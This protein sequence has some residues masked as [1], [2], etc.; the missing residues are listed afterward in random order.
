MAMSWIKGQVNSRSRT[1]LDAKLAQEQLAQE[2]DMIAKDKESARLAGLESPG[3]PS[4]IPGCLAGCG[5]VTQGGL[6]HK[7]GCMGWR[8]NTY[9]IR[10]GRRIIV[11][12]GGNRAMTSRCSES[13]DHRHGGADDGCHGGR[14][15]DQDRKA[16]PQ[17]PKLCEGGPGPIV[18]HEF[19]AK[20][21][22]GNM[23]L[24]PNG[25][26]PKLSTEDKLCYFKERE[27]LLLSAADGWENITL[28]VDSGASDTV[29]PPSV[30]KGAEI[31]NTPK[32]GIEY[33]CAN[34]KPL[35]NLGERRCDAML[36]QGGDVIGMAFQV[37]D[38]GRS[39]LSVSRVCAQG[40]DVVF[41][42]K[43]G[44]YIHLDGDPR[45]AIPLRN[46]GGVFE[47]DV[48]VRPAGFARP[49]VHP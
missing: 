23:R 2:Q 27:G 38:V 26:G 31:Q 17:K 21:L 14:V 8:L 48:W 39:L 12:E 41:S 3:S 25:Y 43:K 44:S 4:P 29:V 1:K 45:K 9:D 49:G 15:Q 35:Y 16:D 33:E 24:I 47:L 11:D 32:V 19:T 28:M 34:G 10:T 46:A 36:S 6:Q 22:F 18:T 13:T 30:C 5:F 42:E 7:I 37:V 20:E 40:H